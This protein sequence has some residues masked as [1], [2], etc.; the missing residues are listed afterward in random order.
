VLGPD[1]VDPAV[2]LLST[3]IGMIMED[4]ATQAI[5]VGPGPTPGRFNDL[6]RAGSDI[7]ALADACEVLLQRRGSD[8]GD[9]SDAVG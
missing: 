5:Q 6:K 4:H 7:S 8:D 2:R 9:G 1:L 3:A